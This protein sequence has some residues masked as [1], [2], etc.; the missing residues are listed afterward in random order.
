MNY[1]MGLVLPVRSSVVGGSHQGSAVLS[2][3]PASCLPEHFY[4]NIMCIKWKLK[5]DGSKEWG[6]KETSRSYREG[7][8]PCLAF[9][10][11]R[12][13]EGGCASE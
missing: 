8:G 2:L 9:S 12:G 1:D 5:R 6:K 4:T 11:D 10:M 3:L 7:M 13:W